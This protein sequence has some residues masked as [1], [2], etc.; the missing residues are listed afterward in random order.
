MGEC[1]IIKVKLLGY[2]SHIA[3]AREVKVEVCGEKRV[4]DLISIPNINIEELVILINGHTARPEDKARPGD[5]VT[6]MPHISGG[7]DSA[8][9]PGK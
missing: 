6:V 8:P 9:L 4:K 1:G 7:L 3:G 5:V 2:L